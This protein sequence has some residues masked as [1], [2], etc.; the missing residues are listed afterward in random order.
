VSPNPAD[1][2]KDS[3]DG[4]LSRLSN[5][6]ATSFVASTANTGLDKPEL[7][8]VVKFD[9]GKKEEHVTFGK[10]GNDVYASR[11]GEPGAAKVD[12]TDFSEVLKAL[13]ELS[14]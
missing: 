9:D 13:D 6:R 11:A 12:P 5:S 1:A 8:V 7:T 14:K 2:N 3:M 4:L 10:A